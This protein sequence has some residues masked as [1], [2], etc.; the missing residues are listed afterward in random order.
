ML[1]EA[2]DEMVVEV[3]AGLRQRIM[4]VDWL[5]TETRRLALEKVWRNFTHYWTD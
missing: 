3:R 2:G 1:Q 4:E 5:D